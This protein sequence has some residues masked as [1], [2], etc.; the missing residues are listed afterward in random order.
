M[1][2]NLNHVTGKTVKGFNLLTLGWTDVYSFVPV[3]FAMLSSAKKEKR[4]NEI[5]DGIDKRTVGYR[6]RINAMM[7]KTDAAIELIRQALNAGIS[8]DYIL[9][10]TWFTNES[11]IKRILA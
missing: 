11:F 2:F 10:D 5:K 1:A 9:M 3:A 4:L 7:P 6:N 8:A